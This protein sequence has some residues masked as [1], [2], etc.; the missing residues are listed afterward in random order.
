MASRSVPASRERRALLIRLRGWSAL[1]LFLALLYPLLRF[2]GFRVRPKP[3]YVTI[4]AP[5][6]ASNYHSEREVILFLRK[7]NPVAVS[8]ICTHLGCRVSYQED[9]DIIECPCHQ[10]RFTPEGKRIAGPARRDLPTYPVE[11]RRDGR[12]R[13]TGYRIRL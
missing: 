9:K 4:Q 5:L 12:G 10:S 7:G 13:T 8:R 1:T 11:I 6:P 2:L 3:R